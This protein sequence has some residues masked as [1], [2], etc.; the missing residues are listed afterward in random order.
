[1]SLPKL[2]RG[3]E[4]KFGNYGN[5]TNDKSWKRGYVRAVVSDAFDNFQRYA[6]IMTNA[7][8]LDVS[9]E[10]DV[11]L[12]ERTVTFWHPSIRSSH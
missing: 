2:F 12:I 6:R 10:E 9:L 4:Q 5:R 8:T 7:L 3:C 11:A 1:M